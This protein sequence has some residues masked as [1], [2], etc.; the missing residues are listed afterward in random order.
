M[1]INNRRRLS[2]MTKDA[3]GTAVTFY[4]ELF[5]CLQL[6]RTGSSVADPVKLSTVKPP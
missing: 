4:G 5:F 1:K 2:G 6:R 3:N